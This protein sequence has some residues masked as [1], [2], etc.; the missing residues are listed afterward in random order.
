V[1]AAQLAPTAQ[2]VAATRSSATVVASILATL[3]LGAAAAPVTRG[4]QAPAPRAA[5]GTTTAAA[6]AVTAAGE[7]FTYRVRPGDTLIGLAARL[8]LEPRRWPEL[9]RRN[10]IADPRRMPRGSAVRIPYAW[11]RI[12]RQAARVT[13]RSGTVRVDGREVAVGALVEA[14]AAIETGADGALTLE[15]ADGSVMTV[16]PATRLSI[17]RLQR[18]DGA[19]A[20]EA[21]LQL[22]R[23]KVESQVRPRGDMGRFEIRTPAA[24]SAVRGTGFRAGF[25]DAGGGTTE[26]LEGRVG[27]DAAGA[28]VTVPAGF[29]TRAEPGRPP[30]P[31]V[32][33][34]PAPSLAALP[35]VNDTATLRWEFPPVGGAVRYRHQV[36]RDARFRALVA[37]SL[38]EVP[39]AAFEGL[40]DGPYWI[41]SRAI[42]PSTIEGLDAMRPIEQRRRL[43]APAPASP[44]AGARSI[45]ERTRFEWSALAGATAYLFELARDAQFAPP[46]EARRVTAAA[47][48]APVAT[49]LAQLAPGAY[50][51]R[52]AAID[53]RGVAGQW[54]AP[55]PFVQK[56]PPVAA[57][58]LAAVPDGAPGRR[59]F[60]WEAAPSAA[61]YEWQLAR[62]PGFDRV[63]RSGRS[64]APRLELEELQPGTW[65]LRVRT[66]DDDGFEAPYGP[67]REF[68]VAWPAWVRVLVPALLLLPTL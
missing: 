58:P 48:D 15:M 13:D 41:R 65:Y 31:P 18:I 66:I 44:V 59:A 52:V 11:L 17:E 46:L 35:T 29:G 47:N 33:L 3:L 55:Q 36:A 39:A 56:P 26:T 60:R 10:A 8:L 63:V 45:G 20:D 37:E 21:V 14:G 1:T 54:S 16:Q 51:W 24:V 28:G 67:P 7:E 5:A 61:A 4:Q 25:A 40:A 50:A 68:A 53:A 57:E 32:P 23:G 64:A 62:R 49:E 43:D 2:R 19:A 6:S 34:L 30:Q 9:Q 22:E 27:V 38:T 12:S 42:D